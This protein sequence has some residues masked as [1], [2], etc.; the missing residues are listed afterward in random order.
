M[1]RLTLLLWATSLIFTGCKNKTQEMPT[2]N[3][4]Y[5]VEVVKTGNADLKVSY[6]ATIKGTKDVEIRP[7]ISGFVTKVFVKEGQCVKKGQVLFSID[8]AQFRAAVLSARAQIKVCNATIATQKLTVENKRLLYSKGIISDYDMKMAENTLQSSQA[9]LLA[10]RS[11]LRAAKD[12]LRWCTITS[13]ADGVIGMLP[14]KTGALVSPSMSTPFTTV[15]DISQVH[16]YFS[17]TEKQLLEMSR[18]S[19]GG[20][21]EAI[22]LFPSVSLLLA[23]GTLYQTQGK[24]DA[25]SG[26]IDQTTGAVS[27]RAT[28][29][30]QQGLLRS[31][32]TATI[33]MP[34]RTH[35]AILVPQSATIEIQDK[36]FVYIV[37]ANNEV[38]SKEIKVEE[39]NNGKVYVVSSGLTSGDKIV[40]EGVQ[41]L[42]NGQKIKPI[43]AAQ[44]A[45]NLA[46]AKQDIKDGK[47]PGEK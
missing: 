9:Q 13:P 44:A 2:G 34:I 20:I 31:G 12:N 45:K 4:E 10:A 19:N 1:K 7:K 38:T 8:D 33:Q 5:T 42:K 21:A 3:N 14:F 29:S 22:K 46:K 11:Q 32:G 28:F 47:M 36:K 18:I 30:N 16:V 39:Q 6:P 37:N 35:N 41:N 43:T 27:M 40:I 26:I 15:S 17:I 25:V 24:I 23:D